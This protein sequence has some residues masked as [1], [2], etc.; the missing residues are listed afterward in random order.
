MI[1]RSIK[2]MIIGSTLIST[3]V[4]VHYM[5]LMPEI[6]RRVRILITKKKNIKLKI[7]L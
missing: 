4:F 1:F 3:G 2:M 5:P 7:K 6:S